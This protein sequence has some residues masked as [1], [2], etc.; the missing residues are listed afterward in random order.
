MRFKVDENLHEDVAAAL[1]AE[2]DNAQTVYDEELRG[3]PDPDIAEAPSLAQRYG[4]ITE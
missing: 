2:E 3:R 4:I 1:R